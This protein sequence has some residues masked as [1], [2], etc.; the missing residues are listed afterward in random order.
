MVGWIVAR[1][2]AVTRGA[3]VAA[4]VGVRGSGTECGEVGRRIVGQG[5]GAGRTAATRRAADELGAEASGRDTME[6]AEAVAARWLATPEAVGATERWASAVDSKWLATPEAVDTGE[7]G[8]A[9]AVGGTWLA[10]PDAVEIRELGTAGCDATAAGT[11]VE[12]TD[13]WTVERDSTERLESTGWSGAGA[14]GRVAI[15]PGA[16]PSRAARPVGRRRGAET[17]GLGA[18]DIGAVDIGIVDTGPLPAADAYGA[19]CALRGMRSNGP[20]AMSCRPP[21]PNGSPSDGW[22]RSEGRSWDVMA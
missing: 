6:V 13:D 8:T 20:S 3:V 15:A 2:G 10:T 17:G 1:A 4:A 16:R 11:P 5:L 9:D 18:V 21:A 19:G 22:C 14:A 12:R 7:L